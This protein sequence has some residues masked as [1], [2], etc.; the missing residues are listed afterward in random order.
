[1]KEQILLDDG[2]VGVVLF[3]MLRSSREA[4]E[5]VLSYP[6]DFM[7]SSPF[8]LRSRMARSTSLSFWL[9]LLF[10]L[11]LK[12]QAQPIV[13]LNETFETPLNGFV[14]SR[15]LQNPLSRVTVANGRASLISR[16]GLQTMEPLP[17]NFELQGKFRFV[18][19]NDHLRICWRSDLQ[20]VGPYGEREGLLVVIAQNGELV[21][22][23]PGKTFGV[24]PNFK[25]GAL[26]KYTDY[27]F[28]IVCFENRIDFYLQD[29]TTP[30]L[31]T[32]SS[33]AK[34]SGLAIYNRELPQ[35]SLELDEVQIWNL[36]GSGL[37]KD[38]SLILHL[39][40]N[41][42][43]KDLTGN[44][45]PA[46]VQGATPAV[47]RFG[48]AGGAYH[49]NGQDQYIVANVTRLPVGD[50]PRT[51]LAWVK[52]EDQREYPGFINYGVGDQ[53]GRIFG[54]GMNMGYGV[55]AFLWGHGRDF[56]SH[57]PLPTGVW[58]FV[59]VRYHQGLA[60]ITVGTE[61]RSYIFPQGLALNTSDNGKLWV[62]AFSTR[63]STVSPPNEGGFAG[64]FKGSL[65][66]V[67]IFNRVLSDQELREIFAAENPSGSD[68]PD[69]DGF[70]TEE[71][72][73]GGANPFDPTSI[74]VGLSAFRAVEL[75]SVTKVGKLYQI[76]SSEDMVTWS[77]FGSSF[78]GT[79]TRTSKFVRVH[80]TQS[81]FWK[82]VAL[83]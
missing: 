22:G 83:P 81:R 49:F 69:G 40:M 66:E 76:M 33:Y 4:R 16:G 36:D 68:D 70:T 17:N 35:C 11:L 74:P 18:G 7:K 30:L 23:S 67:R 45:P 54:L 14:W 61:T 26:Q 41:G 15:I 48:I 42:D 8:H 55:G 80:P 53:D 10:G 43:S 51:L 38:P 82:L 3:P 39:G 24:L 77:P 32:I 59:A 31:S 56:Q 27:W 73:A 60:H 29:F 62:G 64:R 25:G 52:P 63:G 65:D 37:G 44:N 1:M 12:T 57:L 58:N 46:V 2:I 71:E 6:K 78:Q 34:G 75:E 13:V 50:S 19:E 72:Q 28:R 5:R 79:G 47:D 20:P 9:V 21:L